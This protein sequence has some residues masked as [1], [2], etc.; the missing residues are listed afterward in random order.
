MGIELSAGG[1]VKVHTRCL[2]E[3]SGW[4]GILGEEGSGAD[5]Y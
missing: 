4:V 1:A 3:D 2:T 5:A